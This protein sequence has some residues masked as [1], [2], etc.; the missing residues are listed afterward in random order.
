MASRPLVVGATGWARSEAR[1]DGLWSV[2]SIPGSN[3]RKTYRCPGCDQEI[4][5][6]VSHL[7][8][9]PADQDDLDTDYDPDGLL[10]QRR[11]WHTGCW[12]ARE[13]RRPGHRRR[14]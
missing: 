6:G 4:R 7:V 5:P 2:R 3:S 9:W 1:P 11:H 13:R 10:D 8:A 14:T 12:A